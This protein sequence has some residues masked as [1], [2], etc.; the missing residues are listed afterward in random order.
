[1]NL[2][3]KARWSV[4]RL[5][6]ATPPALLA[7]GQKGFNWAW[8]SQHEH[9]ITQQDLLVGGFLVPCWYLNA[10]Y[11]F[12]PGVVKVLKVGLQ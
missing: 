8:V 11:S 6:I 7:S 12:E 10:S 2:T 4:V 1:M 5:N 9:T 3:S